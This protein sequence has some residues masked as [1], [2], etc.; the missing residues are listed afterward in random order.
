M[1]CYGAMRS[2]DESAAAANPCPSCGAV[3]LA[4]YADCR[5][6]WDELLAR[7]FSDFGY[8][9]FH[10]QIVDVYSMQHPAAY[11]R[12]AKSYAAHL[13]GLCCCAERGGEP[14]IQEAVQRWLSGNPALT[15]PPIPGDRGA[16]TLVE[17][18]EA[19]YPEG[20]PEALERWTL[21]AWEAYA[22]AHELARR[23]IR[24]ALGLL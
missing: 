17:V 18:L 3:P 13:T 24:E 15:R 21:A 22:D 7:S 8:A 20:I 6:M 14:A 12:S 2:D 1:R 23:W 9:R 16:I 10:R 19:P 4:G 11:C 5:A